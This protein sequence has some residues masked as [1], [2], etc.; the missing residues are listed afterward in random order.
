MQSLEEDFK[1]SSPRGAVANIQDKPVRDSLDGK[2]PVACSTLKRKSAI[3]IALTVQTH[4]KYPETDF[5]VWGSG[6]SV[7]EHREMRTHQESGNPQRLYGFLKK[8][9]GHS[10]PGNV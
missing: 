4:D 9:G 7:S 3:G 8:S 10:K 1:M 5:A 6:G 2:Q